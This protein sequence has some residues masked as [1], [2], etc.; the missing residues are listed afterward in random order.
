MAKTARGCPKCGSHGT[1]GL[2][3]SGIQQCDECQYRW[4][5]CGDQYCRVYRVYLEP[6]PGFIGCDQCDAAAGGVRTAL[7]AVW[8]ET[9]RAV[10][11][12]LERQEASPKTNGDSPEKSKSLEGGADH[13]ELYGPTRLEHSRESP[14]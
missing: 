14:H 13:G 10:A 9:W 3:R 6:S 12:A 11:R 7:V 4:Q 2:G 5:P 1:W 8:P